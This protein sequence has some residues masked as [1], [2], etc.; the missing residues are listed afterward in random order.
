[1]NALACVNVIANGRETTIAYGKISCLIHMSDEQTRP[2]V[3]AKAADD[4][5]PKV[6]A[7]SY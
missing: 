5:H 6:A 3:I 4:S 7:G 1:M 2:A